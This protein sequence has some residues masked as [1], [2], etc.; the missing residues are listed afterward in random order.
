MH[1]SNQCKFYGRVLQ[2]L[3]FVNGTITINFGAPV[4]HVKQLEFSKVVIL[5]S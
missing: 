4:L 2:T 1:H 5:I 3:V